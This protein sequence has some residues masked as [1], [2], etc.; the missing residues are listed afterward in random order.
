MEDGGNESVIEVDQQVKGDTVVQVEQPL[1]S[2]MI[3][4]E[5]VTEEIEEEVNDS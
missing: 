5:E 2:N 3:W 4:S 1:A